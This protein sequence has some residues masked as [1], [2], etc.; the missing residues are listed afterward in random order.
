[1]T[2]R[3][4]F[5]QQDRYVDWHVM[6]LLRFYYKNFY[7][8]GLMRLR[9]CKLGNKVRL[10]CNSVLVTRFLG[11]TVAYIVVLALQDA[12]VYRVHI[13][14]M[15]FTCSL[16]IQPRS[17]IDQRVR[18]INR[19]MKLIPRLC[20]LCG[21]KLQLSYSV[22][23]SLFLKAGTIRTYI[24]YTQRMTTMEDKLNFLIYFIL[25]MGLFIWVED[26]VAHL[27]WTA[28]SLLIKAF[29]L[30]NEEMAKVAITMHL[31]ILRKDPL[32]VNRLERRLLSLQRLHRSFT[33]LSHQ[34]CN[35]LD[36][37]LVLMILYS[38]SI[39]EMAFTGWTAIFHI[40]I[41]A[42]NLRSNVLA[43]EELLSAA[44]A[45]E[46][47]TWMHVSQSLRFKSIQHDHGIRLLNLKGCNSCAQTIRSSLIP[48]QVKLLKVI[49]PN[50]R[51][52]F[53]IGLAFCTLMYLKYS[54]PKAWQ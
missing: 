52:L 50:R 39:L 38:L 26:M 48:T 23:I 12:W 17:V 13:E 36:L 32:A 24:I 11:L 37:Q 14:V 41:T 2:V 22:I 49:T 34:I 45:P 8:L 43:I 1:M 19:F 42:N 10:T 33:K 31:Q 29:E 20:H 3:R 40:I 54:Y 44:S 9:Y 18:L 27:I 5:V 21:R 7:Y 35:C 15:F 4:Y 25:P 47:A 46:D 51:F 53:R 30:L 16:L 28:F 6:F